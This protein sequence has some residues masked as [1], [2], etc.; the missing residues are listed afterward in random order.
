M[1]KRFENINVN[2]TYIRENLFLFF[3][4]YLC[5]FKKKSCILYTDEKYEQLKDIIIFI[6]IYNYNYNI[7]IYF[8][9]F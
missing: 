8:Y 1:C 2:V 7:R 9:F 4:M 6:I 3:I 5:V